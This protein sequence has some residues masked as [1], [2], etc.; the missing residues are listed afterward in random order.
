MNENTAGAGC[1]PKRVHTYVASQAVY[2]AAGKA[3]S[4][5]H[6]GPAFLMHS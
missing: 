4:N 3:E 2:A 5:N 1:E 6:V